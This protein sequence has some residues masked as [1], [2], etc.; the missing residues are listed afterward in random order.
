MARP[1]AP[2]R[3]E[4]GR[5]RGGGVGGVSRLVQRSSTEREGVE[6]DDPMMAQ[7]QL[8]AQKKLT[9]LRERE[10]ELQQQVSGVLKIIV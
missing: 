5:G 10:R 3:E 8:V 1:S 9:T 6:D 7:V 4:R 2:G